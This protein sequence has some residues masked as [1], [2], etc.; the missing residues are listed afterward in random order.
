MRVQILG[1]DSKVNGSPTLYLSDRPSY[2]VQGWRLPDRADQVEI[3]HGLLRFLQP[4][5][6]LGVKLEDT[7]WGTFLVSGS[8]VQDSE[9]LAAMMIPEHEAAVEVAIGAQLRR[10]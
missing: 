10:D 3:P 4:D 5:T 7:G 6:C 1:T 8:S 2:L 9:A